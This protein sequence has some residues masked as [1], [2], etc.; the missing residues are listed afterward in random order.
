MD[1][2][3]KVTW[4]DHTHR[5]GLSP[6]CVILCRSNFD[7]MVKIAP[8]CVHLRGATQ[9][10]R[11]VAQLVL[12]MA[13]YHVRTF[14]PVEVGPS[15]LDSGAIAEAWAFRIVFCIERTYRGSRVS[16]DGLCV[17]VCMCVYM[18]VCVC[19][20]MCV[21]VYVYVY[22]RVCVHPAVMRYTVS[23]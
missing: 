21:C 14:Y 17:C 15:A 13:E 4:H 6:V 12:S 23:W 11:T 8:H 9:R 16:C 20:C 18:Y 2:T 19:V 7:R 3:G 10:V 5:N 1:G 22:V